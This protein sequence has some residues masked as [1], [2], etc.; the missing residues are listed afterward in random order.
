MVQKQDT[1]SR[2]SQKSLQKKLAPQTQLPKLL[3]R[4]TN[5][6]YLDKGIGMSLNHALC[7]TQSLA[8]I[9]TSNHFLARLMDSKKRSNKAKKKTRLNLKNIQSTQEVQS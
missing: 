4:L 9:S 3:W 2:L 5:Q 7:D 6:V 8:M 1:P